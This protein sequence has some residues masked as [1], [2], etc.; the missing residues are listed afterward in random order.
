MR[1]VGSQ[2][3]MD[4]LS[5]FSAIRGVDDR[6]AS[7]RFPAQGR[8]ARGPARRR[9][10]RA[11]GRRRTIRDATPPRRGPAPV[12]GG[13]RVSSKP[14]D[15]GS[16]PGP[17]VRRRRRRCHGR[18]AG[19]TPR[20]EAQLREALHGTGYSSRIGDLKQ[21]AGCQDLRTTFSWEQIRAKARLLVQQD[22]R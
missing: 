6:V 5:L 4:M 11:G 19:W 1:Q 18:R 14:E 16:K 21:Q 12:D 8:R 15:A 13:D 3:N 9:R 20:Q 7:Q 2:Y 10:S 17:E 22:G